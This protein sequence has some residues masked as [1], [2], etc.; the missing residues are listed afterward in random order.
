MMVC[1]SCFDNELEL[2]ANS[3]LCKTC[4]NDNF[5]ETDAEFYEAFIMLIDHNGKL[6]SHNRKLNNLLM[7]G[8]YCVEEHW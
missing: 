2:T 5:V 3:S 7:S 1:A 4:G 8:L 6:E